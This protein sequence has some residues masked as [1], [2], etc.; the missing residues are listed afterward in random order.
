MSLP[1]C[2]VEWRVLGVAMLDQLQPAL[3][4]SSIQA[5]Q[6]LLQGLQECT[7]RQ[8]MGWTLEYS[9]DMGLQG[10]Q[11]VGRKSYLAV[12]GC[13]T[14]NKKEQK[15]KK[16]ALSCT[17]TSQ[18]AMLGPTSEF[19]TKESQP[20]HVAEEECGSHGDRQVALAARAAI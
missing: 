20:C 16:K 17:S 14:T 4:G 8:G 13:N 5:S 19:L 6:I 12:S 1:V 10:P 9:M 2:V 15:L 11:H 18:F 7:I 3:V